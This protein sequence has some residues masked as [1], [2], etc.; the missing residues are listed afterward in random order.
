MLRRIGWAMAQ[1]L[2][3]EA[4]QDVGS[5]GRLELRELDQHDQSAGAL[6]QRSYCT[7]I[8]FALDQVAFPVPGELAVLDLWRAH[9]DAQHVR[10]LAPAVLALAARHA[11]VVGVAQGGDQFFAQ[12]AHGMA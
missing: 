8:A 1:Q 5:T 4:L 9:M 7:G 11:L 2:V 10:D 6:H 12:F 3:R